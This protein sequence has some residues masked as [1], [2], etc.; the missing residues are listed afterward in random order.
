MAS[1][2][3]LDVYHR[4]R[5]QDDAQLLIDALPYARFLGMHAI[6]DKG[7]LLFH[8]PPVECNIGNPTLPALHGGAVGGFMEM[9]A[10][11][12]L[13]MSIDHDKLPDGE[14]RV[15]KLVDFSVD[16]I[17]ACRFVD[18]FAACEV[19]RQG[20]KLANVAVKVWQQDREI[21]TTTARSHYLLG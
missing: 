14:P 19:V 2:D 16:Y 13:L 12:F 8:L 3:F 9:A 4:A 17:R 11:T 15:P 5:E 10:V 6:R 18:T 20:R 1:S 7:E 21:P